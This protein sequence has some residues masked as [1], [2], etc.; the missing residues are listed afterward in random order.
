LE[1]NYVFR[2]KPNIAVLPFYDAN[3]QAK[4]VEFGRTV[5]AMLATTLR[6]NTNFIVLEPG[7]LSQILTEQAVGISG[8]TREMSKSFSDL[9]NVEVLLCC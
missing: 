8:I 4:E 7:E 5:S 9:Y 2:G 1:D 6:S 3:A